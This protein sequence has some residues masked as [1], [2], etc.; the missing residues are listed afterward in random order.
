MPEFDFCSRNF[1]NINLTSI[2][3][4]FVAPGSNVIS[5]VG[6]SG[7]EFNLENGYQ[8]LGSGQKT[9]GE[10][11][12]QSAI[13]TGGNYMG[14]KLGGLFGKYSNGGSFLNT[15]GGNTL[16]NGVA[17]TVQNISEQATK[18]DEKPK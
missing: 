10:F 8:G 1:G 7:L 5:A 13:G 15:F 3:L 14:K 9:F 17:N 16:G 2:G 11:M 18:Q 6:G 4:N 12:L